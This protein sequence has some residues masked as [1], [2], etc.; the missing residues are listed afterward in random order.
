MLVLSEEASVIVVVVEV[1][2]SNAE[3]RYR[4]V[5]SHDRDNTLTH[6]RR[7]SGLGSDALT[8]PSPYYWIMTMNDCAYT[9]IVP[10]EYMYHNDRQSRSVMNP[11][12]EVKV[13]I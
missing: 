3:F 5:R 4:A 8:Q 11:Q 13:S 1:Q 10:Q 7:A 6:Q 2:G 9:G 12:R